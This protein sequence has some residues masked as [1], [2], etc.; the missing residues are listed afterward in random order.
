MQVSL[1]TLAG[2]DR[3]LSITLPA[4]KVSQLFDQQVNQFKNKANLNGFRPGKVPLAV[5]KKKYGKALLHD[6]ADELI[7]TSLF[8]AITEHKLNPAGSPSIEKMDEIKLGEGFNYVATVEVFPEFEVASLEKTTFEKAQVDVAE[9]DI[10][11]FVEKMRQ[12]HA[13]WSEKTTKDKASEGDRLTI[14]FEGKIKGELFEGGS[15]Q[16]VTLTLG[17]GRFLPEFEK[18]LTGC[19]VG[20][21][22]VITFKFPKDYK[23]DLAGKKVEFTIQVNKIEQSELPEL[24]KAFFEQLKVKD[25]ATLRE[26]VKSTITDQSVEKIQGLIKSQVMDKLLE[27]NPIDAPKSLIT[28]EIKRLKEMDKMRAMMYQSQQGISPQTEELPDEA[29]QEAAVRGVKLGLV[30]RQFADQHKVEA[31][32][33]RVKEKVKSLAKNYQSPESVEQYYLNDEKHLGEI[34]GMILEEMI[35]DRACEMAS[36]KINAMSFDELT[37]VA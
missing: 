5:I 32:M 28:E 23:E 17:E 27:L 26:E 34:K 15:A 13:T 29:Y 33:G 2:L 18:G 7:R 4:E 8:E 12:Q 11:Q 25:L 19:C 1:E 14:D 22:K 30:L 37:K 20:E 6:V 21:E 24:N 10:D 3:K 36:L 35:V 31:D 16:N 9:G